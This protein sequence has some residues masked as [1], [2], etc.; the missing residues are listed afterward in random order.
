MGWKTLEHQEFQELGVSGMEVTEGTI[1][2]AL[3]ACDTVVCTSVFM[4][5]H[6]WMD[7]DN[8]LE[9]SSQNP[10]NSREDDML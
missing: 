10:I 9:C 8:C 3:L 1:R 6:F 5:N 7:G 2:T 4:A